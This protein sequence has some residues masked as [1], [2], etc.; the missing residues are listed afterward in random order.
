MISE[1]N[2]ENMLRNVYGVP[3][4]KF[5]PLP[6]KNKSLAILK[7]KCKGTQLLLSFTLF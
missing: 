4:I 1:N 6:F 2:T 5:Q 7:V 3:Q